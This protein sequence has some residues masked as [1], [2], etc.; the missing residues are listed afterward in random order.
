VR[1]FA[2]PERA[3]SSCLYQAR[4]TR[5]AAPQR[6]PCQQAH[7]ATMCVVRAGLSIPFFFSL[8]SRGWR[9]RP[10]GS[11]PPPVAAVLIG[12]FPNAAPRPIRVADRSTHAPSLGAQLTSSPVSHSLT[13]LPVQ[14]HTQC[15]LGGLY[16]LA[17]GLT[18]VLAVAATFPSTTERPQPSN[19]LHWIRHYWEFSAFHW[20]ASRQKHTRLRP[21]RHPRLSH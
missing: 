12:I 5:H 16:G 10:T 3:W 7:C 18:W 2:R 21:R 6:I 15:T 14:Q 13:P 1:L 9:S 17:S 8:M 11:L 20:L 19:M 4:S